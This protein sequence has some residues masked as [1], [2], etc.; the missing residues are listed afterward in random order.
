MLRKQNEDIMTKIEIIHP[1]YK[2]LLLPD[3]YPYGGTFPIDFIH[4]EGTI[5]VFDNRISFI[6][7]DK[8]LVS[9][10]KFFCMTFVL[11]IILAL[12]LLPFG[13]YFEAFLAVLMFSIGLCLYG[14]LLHEQKMNIKG[15]TWHMADIK[16]IDYKRNIIRFSH[17]YRKIH[18]EALDQFLIEIGMQ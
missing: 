11:G 17:P 4:L 10:M 5:T 3:S 13:Y 9:W 7:G 2:V 8:R 15:I 6:T 12:T 1:S 18:I 14:Y 16:K